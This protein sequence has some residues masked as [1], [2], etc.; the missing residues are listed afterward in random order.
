MILQVRVSEMC[1]EITYRMKLLKFH[2]KI[3]ALFLI[4]FLAFG[5][6]GRVA[7]AE[8]T[9][10]AE[11]KASQGTDGYPGFCILSTISIDYFA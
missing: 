1:K 9:T 11:C 2:D 4:A 8:P 6:L 3:K 5:F 10:E 7:F